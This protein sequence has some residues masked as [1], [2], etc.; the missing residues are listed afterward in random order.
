MLR[1]F[2]FAGGFLYSF[3]TCDIPTAVSPKPTI[4]ADKSWVPLDLNH[5]K[6]NIDATFVSETG[7]VAFGMVIHN[8]SGMVL[9]FAAGPLLFGASTVLHAE[10]LSIRER[11]RLTQAAG[12]TVQ[13]IENDSLLALQAITQLL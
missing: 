3:Q 8:A 4:I 12:F 7:V 5:L 13:V 10:L 11:L 9:Y 6:M 2:E 1:L